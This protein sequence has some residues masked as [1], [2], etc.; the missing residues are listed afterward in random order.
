MHELCRQPTTGFVSL[1]N[2]VLLSWYMH[3]AMHSN[4]VHAAHATNQA[5]RLA[6]EISPF[7][8]I[9]AISIHSS[10]AAHSLS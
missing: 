8:Q 3:Q 10:S 2:I 6:L 7:W 1:G 9:T 4:Q 5:T